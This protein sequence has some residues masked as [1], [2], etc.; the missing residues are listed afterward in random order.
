MIEAAL[1]G[2]LIAILVFVRSTRKPPPL[3]RP[4]STRELL[5]DAAFGALLG[6]VCW[7]LFSALL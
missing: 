2:A 1:A 4:W 6:L 5:L 3:T 7:A